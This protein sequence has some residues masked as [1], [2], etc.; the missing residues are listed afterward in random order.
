M[1]NAGSD[2]DPFDRVHSLM[3]N[4]K[5]VNALRL[6]REPGANAISTSFR[7]DPNHAWYC[8]G[9]ILYRQGDFKAAS[10]A[11]KRSLSSRPDDAEALEAI[12]NCYDAQSRPKLAERYFRRALAV[13]DKPLTVAKRSDITFNLANALYDQG[14]LDEAIDLYRQLEDGHRS[15]RQ[16]AKKNL[17]LAEKKAATKV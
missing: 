2:T 13:L 10:A 4:G 17:H 7:F 8:V 6:L 3:K 12:G 16:V 14:R 9:D 5:F 11:F 15:I 1:K